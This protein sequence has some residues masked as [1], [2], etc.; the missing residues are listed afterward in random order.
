MFIKELSKYYKIDNRE[1][2]INTTWKYKVKYEVELI[3]EFQNYS[4]CQDVVEI[5]IK[6]FKERYQLFMIV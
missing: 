6:V 5:L 4:Q 2:F 3:I 1:V